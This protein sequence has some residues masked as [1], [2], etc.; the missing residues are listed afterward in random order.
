MTRPYARLG[1]KKPR[2]DTER[3]IKLELETLVSQIVRLRTPFCVLC[4][5]NNWRV[6]ECG[7]FW[8]RA[9]PPTEF[10]LLNLNTLCH[11]CNQRHEKDAEPY[12]KYMLEK[13]GQKVFD[14]L[15][16]RAH[17]NFKMGYV[18]LFNLREEMKA[19]LAEERRRVA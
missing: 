18:E 13:L 9:M 19:L 3:Q 5:D 14:Q 7:H 15:E 1:S 6:L 4:G 11:P 17:S 10:D 2:R 8:H 12:R 16:W